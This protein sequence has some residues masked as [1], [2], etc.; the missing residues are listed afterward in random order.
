MAKSLAK[1]NERE[2]N[3]VS[4]SRAVVPSEPSIWALLA[5]KLPA[6]LPIYKSLF[7]QD[8]DGS[9]GGGL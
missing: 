6:F 3:C 7:G 5:G 9:L 4:A 8:S 2:R 1:S